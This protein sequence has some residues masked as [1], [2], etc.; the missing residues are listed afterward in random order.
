MDNGF[1]W[2][3]PWREQTKCVS[4]ELSKIW[5]EGPGKSACARSGVGKPIWLPRVL[6]NKVLVVHSH[7]HFFI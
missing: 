6:V 4:G 2:E 1:Q 3:K 5:K 7:L